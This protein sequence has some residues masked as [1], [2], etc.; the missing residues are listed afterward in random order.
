[1]KQK[2]NFFR[3]LASNQKSTHLIRFFLV[4]MLNTGVSY[5]IYAGLLFAGVGYQ[6]ANFLA[7]VVGVLFSFKTQGHLV[8]RNSDNRLLGRFVISWALIYICNIAL[9][10]RIMTLGFDAYSAGAL[11]LPFSVALSYLAQ[12]YFVFGE[13]TRDKSQADRT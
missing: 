12:R 5:L 2:T 7:L 3:A 11:S 10:G 8:F 9:I 6:L 13:S 1:M 4:G